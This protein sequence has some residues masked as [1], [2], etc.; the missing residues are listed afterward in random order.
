[1]SP[2][3]SDVAVERFF[4]ALVWNWLIGGTDAHA[5]NYSLLIANGQVRLAPLYDVASTLPYGTHERKLKLA[6]KIG[7]DYRVAPLHNNWGKAAAEMGIN[8]GFAYHRQPCCAL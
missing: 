4:D 6:M 2:R 1:M 7:G 5:K 3:N 8:T